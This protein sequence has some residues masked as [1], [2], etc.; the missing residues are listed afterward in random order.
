MRLFTIQ[1]CYISSESHQNIPH[2][3]NPSYVAGVSIALLFYYLVFQ[4]FS[5]IDDIAQMVSMCP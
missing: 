2:I 1:I 5:A 3:K 4:D